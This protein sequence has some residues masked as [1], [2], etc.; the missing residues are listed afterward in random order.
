M[1]NTNK[2]SLNLTKTKD[3]FFHRLYQRDEIPLKLPNVSIGNQFIEREHSMKFLGVL[4]DENITWINH[5][6]LIENKISKNIG[7]LY[8]VKPYLNQICLNYIYFS[9]IHCHLNCTNIA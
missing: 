6:K 7:I 1:F 3:T 4:L 8:E 9:F 5:L 2:L